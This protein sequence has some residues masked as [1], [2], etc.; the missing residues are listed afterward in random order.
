MTDLLDSP[1]R[2]AIV[3]AVFVANAFLIVGFGRLIGCSPDQLHDHVVPIILGAG[4]L[5]M[6]ESL[7]FAYVRR[8]PEKIRAWSNPLEWVILVVLIVAVVATFYMG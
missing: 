6:V 1:L 2:K 8:D 5:Y 3:F 7:V 4:V